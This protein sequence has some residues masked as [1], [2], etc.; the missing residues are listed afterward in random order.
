MSASF[1]DTITQSLI[2]MI[3]ESAD[4]ERLP[5]VRELMAKYGV[6]QATV[7]DAYTTLREM[8]LITS[9][10]GRGSFVVKP[11]GIGP[12]GGKGVAGPRSQIRSLLILAN[13]SMNERC[14]LVQN[15]IVEVVG[16]EG[17]KVV[18]MSYH[19]TGHL[20]EML[21]S[22]PT[23]DAIILQS[24][25]EVIPVRLLASLQGKTRA[26][27]VDGHT[28]AGV[29]IDRM[30]IDW[31]E[32]L[33][34]AIQHLTDLGHR[35]VTLISLD[36]NAQPILGARRYFSRMASRQDA[37]IDGQIVTL[38]GL[39]HPTQSIGISLRRE[40]STLW[41]QPAS[42]APTALIFMGFSDGM[43]I[44]EVM[45]DLEI[46]VPQDL[47]VVILGHPD[48]PTEHLGFFTMVGGGHRAG[49][50]ALVEI[51]RSRLDS[52]NRWPQITYLDCMMKAQESTAYLPKQEGSF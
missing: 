10:V 15:Y 17:G 41:Q 23:F 24:H 16:A 45:R 27:V 44:R 52:P 4:G 8:G 18:Q 47:S 42:Q 28:V 48:V 43:G 29:D 30:G 7:Q 37:R 38:E 12:S 40:M 49:A 36:S 9:Q 6:G 33:D 22:I 14:S 5:T 21:R 31:E 26:L 3:D 39:K 25:Y 35:R 19:D 20:L 50:E 34:A 1:T 51:A 2:R 13:S 11:G 46:S 32:A